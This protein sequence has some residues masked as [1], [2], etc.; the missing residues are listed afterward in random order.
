LLACTGIRTCEAFKLHDNDF[1][2]AAG[3]LRVPA[4]KC[5]PGRMLPLHPSVVRALRRF[6][7]IRRARFPLT[8]TFF[9]GPFGRPLRTSAAQWTFRRLA[10]GIP[11]NGVRS[12]LRL[13][14]FR[15]TFA[16][17]LI[18]RWSRQRAPLAHRLVLLSRYLGHKY[19]QHTYWYV[20]REP[21]A[22]KAAA[23]R[24]EHF[25]RQPFSA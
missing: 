17:K 25:Q 12:T 14:D 7:S 15:H 22:L 20:Q 13:Y 6:Q 11:S 19:F 23:T 8:G 9:T 10:E 1:D 16:T 18:A 2:A 3:T 24:F 5:S 21:A 4:T